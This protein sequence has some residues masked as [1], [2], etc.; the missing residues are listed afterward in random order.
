VSFDRNS[1]DLQ[2]SHAQWPATAKRRPYAVQQPL[3]RQDD[4]PIC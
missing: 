3:R 1:T 2:L 4:M